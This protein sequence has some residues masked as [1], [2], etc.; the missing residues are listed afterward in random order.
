MSNFLTLNSNN[1]CNVLGGEVE[2]FGGEVESSEGE[3]S[4]APPQ[5]ETVIVRCYYYQ[6]V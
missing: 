1:L 5:D 2:H 6:R 3:A 4:F